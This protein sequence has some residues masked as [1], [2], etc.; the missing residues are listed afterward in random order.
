MTDAAP[1]P[2]P[3]NTSGPNGKLVLGLLLIGTGKPAGFAQ[4]GAT[5]EAYL[6]SLAPWLGLVIVLAATTA[7]SGH[8]ELGIAFFLIA[9][10]NLLA[11][12][13]IAEVFCRLWDRREHWALYANVLN[14]SQWLV[15]GVALLLLPVASL[16]FALG[17]PLAVATGLVLAGWSAY[18]LWFHWFA[19]RHALNL[20]RG[21]ATVVMLAVV[22]GT[23][24]LLQIP[25]VLVGR[26]SVDE[27]AK[28]LQAEQG[29]SLES[30]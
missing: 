9:V 17:A 27:M 1:P 18:V 30:K 28:N 8:A 20:S 23:F 12:G 11:P 14:C 26:S 13:V 22:F 4:F 5:R 2:K 15:A 29:K 21:R 25:S 16:T 10:C 3:P 19:A 24:V 6:A 7:W